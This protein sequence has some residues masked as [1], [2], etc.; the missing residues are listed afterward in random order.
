MIEGDAEEE[1]EIGNIYDQLEAEDVPVNEGE[2][3]TY[4]VERLLVAP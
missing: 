2:A 1:P 3:I 4:I